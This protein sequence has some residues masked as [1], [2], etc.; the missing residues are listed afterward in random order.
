MHV[1]V[2]GF[3]V[4]CMSMVPTATTITSSK[5]SLG[6]IKASSSESGRSKMYGYSA[7]WKK[8]IALRNVVIKVLRKG[9]V[10]AYVKYLHR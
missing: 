2:S 9:K 6:S 8:I 1:I 7:D 10:H 5:I 4:T 3:R